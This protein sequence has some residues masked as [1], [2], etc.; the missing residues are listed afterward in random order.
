MSIAHLLC[1]RPSFI[2]Q[3]SLPP[4]LARKPDSQ[5]F[6]SHLQC[7]MSWVFLSREVFAHRWFGFVSSAC[8]LWLCSIGQLQP[9]ERVKA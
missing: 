9:W 2:L 4:N 7:E 3:D 8:G 1:C 5:I 6:E